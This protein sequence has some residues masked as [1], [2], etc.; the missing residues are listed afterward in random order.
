MSTYI[1]DPQCFMLVLCENGAVK[2][3]EFTLLMHLTFILFVDGNLYRRIDAVR[4]SQSQFA[5]AP[6]VLPIGHPVHGQFSHSLLT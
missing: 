4:R 2:T 5:F 1:P 6:S 3:V